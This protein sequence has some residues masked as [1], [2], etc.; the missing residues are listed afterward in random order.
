MKSTLIEDQKQ[1]KMLT[2]GEQQ[3][4]GEMAGEGKPEI[5]QNVRQYLQQVQELVHDLEVQ[6]LRKKGF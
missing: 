3:I 5:G 4:I 1:D 6:L 2:V